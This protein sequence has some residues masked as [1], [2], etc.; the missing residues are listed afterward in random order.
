MPTA[1]LSLSRHL[2]IHLPP[3][4]LCADFSS[5]A[6]LDKCTKTSHEELSLAYDT[7]MAK[8]ADSVVEREK[9]LAPIES[10]L[11]CAKSV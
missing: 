10:F 4:S 6:I 9:C 5:K 7:C 1:C 8:A 11:D 2:T 3:P